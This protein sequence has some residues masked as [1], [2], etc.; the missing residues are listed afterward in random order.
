MKKKYSFM[1]ENLQ[2]IWFTSYLKKTKKVNFIFDKYVK[3]FILNLMETFLTNLKI[4][5]NL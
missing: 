4:L 5:I 2:H 3:K 1:G